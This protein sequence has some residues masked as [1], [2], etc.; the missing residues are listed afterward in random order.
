M[1]QNKNI[2]HEACDHIDLS[3]QVVHQNEIYT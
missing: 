3:I 2:T 1:K